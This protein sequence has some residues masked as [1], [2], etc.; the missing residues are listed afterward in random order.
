MRAHEPGRSPCHSPRRSGSPDTR[1][2]STASLGSRRRQCPCEARPETHLHRQHPGNRPHD[3]CT[4]QPKQ[5]ARDDEGHMLPAAGSSA[6]SSRRA[7]FRI[8]TLRLAMEQPSCDK[9]HG[10]QTPHVGL[11]A[12]CPSL[13]TEPE[14]PGSPSRHSTALQT[15]RG[16]GIRRAVEPRLN[17]M[18]LDHLEQRRREGPASYARPPIPLSLRE[19]TTPEATTT[20]RSSRSSVALP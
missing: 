20:E 12:A 18:E 8:V 3:A 6:L 9:A 15:R 2:S 5:G 4:L 7:R 11:T 10:A 14:E 1:M 19:T 16:Q 13:S 17:D